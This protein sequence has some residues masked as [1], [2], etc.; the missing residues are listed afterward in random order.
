M[1]RV[2]LGCM[3]YLVRMIMF[4]VARMLTRMR[5]RVFVLLFFQL[6]G[7]MRRFGALVVRMIM[8]GMRRL[9]QRRHAVR[10]N[11]YAKIGLFDRRQKP[12]SPRF[13]PEAVEDPGVGTRERR[14]LSGRRFKRMRVGAFGEHRQNPHEVST[15]SA[16][17]LNHGIDRGSD[18][19][20]F[21][22]GRIGRVR[23]R[24]ARLRRGARRESG[25]CSQ[26]E[27]LQK[28]RRVNRAVAGRELP[29][30]E[31]YAED[32]GSAEDAWIRR[33]VSTGKMKEDMLNQESVRR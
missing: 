24:T 27:P 4:M 2:V 11:N 20:R 26:C 28:A 1:R 30:P 33:G 5:M 6:F 25:K 19:K 7:P 3:V 14:K 12:L 9:P 18:K 10:R 17:E 22:L 13:H 32:T 15:R 21:A 8:P 16:R 23:K 31:A 29:L